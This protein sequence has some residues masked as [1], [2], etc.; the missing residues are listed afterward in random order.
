MRRKKRLS[1]VSISI[2]AI[3]SLLISF[4][5]NNKSGNNNE[6]TIIQDDV[7]VHFIDVSQGDCELILDK[8]K[9]VLIDGGEKDK[10]SKVTS[11]LKKLN[12]KEINYMI[13]THPHSD[14]IGG[15][16]KQMEE[17]KVDNLI[18]PNIKESLAPTTKIYSDLLNTAS[19]KN[20]NIIEAKKDL[21]FSLN[22]GTLKI[23][24]PVRQD[25]NELNSFSVPAKFECR[26]KSFL[27]CGDAQKD[28]EE[29]LIKSGQ[30]L[31][32]NV[33]KVNHHGSKTSNTYEFLNKVNADY[34]VI[35]VG[36][37]NKYNLPN[38]EVL[39]RLS[40]KKIYRT[41]QNGDIKMTVEEDKIKVTT[42]K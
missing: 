5:I 7:S 22:E 9:V 11:Y 13:A 26:G 2:I 27:F 25:Y 40:G 15:L 4:A 1:I 12:I 19:A 29:D 17:F 18:M 14:H 38:K 23:L 35:E 28:S 3:I 31:K 20:I 8:G 16:K 32:S 41:D 33:F 36:K 37:N 6:E 24:G 21:N 34:Y 42:Q 30:D 39:S 10:A